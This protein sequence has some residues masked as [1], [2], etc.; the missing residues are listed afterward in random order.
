M[1]IKKNFVNIAIKIIIDI[2][3]D[4]LINFVVL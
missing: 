1:I 4:Q 2:T 3:H